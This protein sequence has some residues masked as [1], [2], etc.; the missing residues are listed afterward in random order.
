MKNWVSEIKKSRTSTSDASL[1]GRPAGIT[2][3]KM[4]ENMH[5]MTVIWL[6]FQESVFHSMD[7]LIYR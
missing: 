3:P 6:F 1:L 5:K 7:L 2:T 4:L